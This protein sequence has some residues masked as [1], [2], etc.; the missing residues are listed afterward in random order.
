[1]IARNRERNTDDVLTKMADGKV[2]IGYQAAD[3][4]LIDHVGNYLEAVET[5][6][7]MINDSKIYSIGGKKMEITSIEQL[8]A[9]FPEFVLQ[10]QENAAKKAA[11]DM[12]VKTQSEDRENFLKFIE[13]QFDEQTA[14]EFK[15]LFDSDITPDQLKAVKNMKPKKDDQPKDDQD[16]E[17]KKAAMLKAIQDAGADNPGPDST[18]IES[19]D[20]MVLVREYQAEHKC[21]IYEAMRAIDAANPELRKNF[22]RKANAAG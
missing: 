16:D 7:T 14:A 5:A 4:G 6:A 2:F 18:I 9:A 11:E 13:I 22:I 19:K 17:N 3:A 21:G 20:Y 15:A 1:M 8:T 12:R 10:I